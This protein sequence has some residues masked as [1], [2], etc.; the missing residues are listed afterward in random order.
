MLCSRNSQMTKHKNAQQAG[1]SK[2]SH[3]EC[4]SHPR[5]SLL[6]T[7][8]SVCTHNDLGIAEWIFMHR[9]IRK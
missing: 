9:I 2:T 3:S 1:G 6:K 8:Q 7:P 5:E 4:Y